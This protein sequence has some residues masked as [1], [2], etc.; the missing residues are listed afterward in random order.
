MSTNIKVFLWCVG[1][2]IGFGTI[3]SPFYLHKAGVVPIAIGIWGTVGCGVG[4]LALLIR[5]FIQKVRPSGTKRDQEVE[6]SHV[7]KL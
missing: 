1:A 5:Y 3:V 6:G 7:Q 4:L 2:G